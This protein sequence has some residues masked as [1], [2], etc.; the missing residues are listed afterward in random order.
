MEINRS[1]PSTPPVVRTLRNE[2]NQSLDKQV[3]SNEKS[4]KQQDKAID[5]VLKKIDG[6]NE[7]LKSAN[8]SLK[9]NLHEE[10]N[11]YYI[12]IVDQQT[13]EVIKEVPPKKLLDIYVAMKETIGLFIDKKI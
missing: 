3:E 7:F 9:F 11:E 6:V 5:D 4:E 12:T 10:L 1:L 13:N 8:T 2:G